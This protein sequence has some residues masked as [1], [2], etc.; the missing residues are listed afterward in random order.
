MKRK[1]L[2]MFAVIV[3]L[4][5]CLV[6][7][8]MAQIHK[9]SFVSLASGVPGVLYEPVTP[10]T[11]AEIAVLVMHTGADYLTFTPCPELA[12]RGYRALCANCSTSKSG[13]V[14]D[15]DEDKRHGIPYPIA[16][17]RRANDHGP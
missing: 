17:T 6:S 13:F 11:K 7:P 4:S 9:T 12:K 2:L 1:T 3:V 14:S 5:F 10:G 15:D 8:S 16:I